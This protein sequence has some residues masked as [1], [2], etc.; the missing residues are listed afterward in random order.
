V[1]FHDRYLFFLALFY[2]LV[3]E[4]WIMF[5]YDRDFCFVKMFRKVNDKL[6]SLQTSSHFVLKAVDLSTEK[7]IWLMI[8]Y[9][10]ISNRCH[11]IKFALMGAL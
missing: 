1:S 10:L 7:V 2:I 11:V 6:L 9:Q 8:S 5:L 3:R 4:T